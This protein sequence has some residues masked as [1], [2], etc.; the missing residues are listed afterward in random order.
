MDPAAGRNIFFLAKSSNP[1]KSEIK[2]RV[3]HY[4]LYLS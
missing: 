1:Y 3:L 4:D 2:G